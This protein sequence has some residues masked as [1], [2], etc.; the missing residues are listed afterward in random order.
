MHD[1][2]VRMWPSAATEHK[3][4]LRSRAYGRGAGLCYIKISISRSRF[5]REAAKTRRKTVE[6]QVEIRCRP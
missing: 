6:L 5:A 3:T 4:A 2:A 1:G